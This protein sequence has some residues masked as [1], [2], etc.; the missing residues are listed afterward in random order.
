MLDSLGHSAI[1]GYSQKK[2]ERLI[3]RVR[4][5]ESCGYVWRQNNTVAPERLAAWT[6]LPHAEA[7][8]VVLRQK[9][10]VGLCDFF[11]V[12]HMLRAHVWLRVER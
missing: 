9:V 1:V 7:V 2:A 5:R 10:V 3:D 4:I 8:Q 11:N 12:L 6:K